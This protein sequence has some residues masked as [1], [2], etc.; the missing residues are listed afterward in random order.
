MKPM[1]S[2]KWR[3]S[4]RTGAIAVLT[5]LAGCSAKPPGCADQE[6]LGVIRNIVTTSL[7]E[8]FSAAAED[9]QD[10]DQKAR[11]LNLGDGFV[12]GL[13]VELVN[14]VN[15]GYD[16]NAKKFS[17]AAQLSAIPALTGEGLKY[18]AAYTVQRTEDDKSK[19]LV[20][21]ERLKPF[22]KQLT[23]RPFGLYVD[24]QAKAQEAVEPAR[25]AVA[26][27]AGVSA[28]AGT[29]AQTQ[30]PAEAVP[31]ADASV[32]PPGPVA[33]AQTSPSFD[34]AMAS[35]PAERLICSNEALAFAD[36]QLASVY[37]ALLQATQ[38]PMA[39]D[40]LKR[41]QASWRQTE[42]DACGDPTCMLTAYRQRQTYLGGQR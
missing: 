21:V 4:A 31:A 9:V 1:K 42:R 37:R 16:T 41:S 27:P 15:N 24:A 40:A 35:T 25:A 12:T 5:A 28:A 6:T 39:A 8:R 34:C 20:E 2:E 17:C 22:I 3:L 29:A 33:A 13:K 19:F 32:P 18:T 36:R 26:E 14:V 38:D 11:I 23:E 30:A 10:T 7:H